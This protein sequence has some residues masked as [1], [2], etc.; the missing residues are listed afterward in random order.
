MQEQ[1][2][3]MRL[4]DAIIAEMD[5]EATTT[6]RLFEVIPEDKLSWQPHPKAMSLGEL[7]MHIAEIP[8]ALAR[9]GQTDVFEFT[10][11]PSPT[12]PE[13]R[14]QILTAFS[15]ALDD[16]KSIV[17]ATSDEQALATWKLTKDSRTLMEM[18]RVAFWRALL[19]NH[20][21]HHRGQL[22]TYLRILD[23]PLPS[24]YGPSA[25]VNPFA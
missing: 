23:V 24:I 1:S 19:L 8:G 4:A 22:S 16:A 5:Q 15:K 3:Q 10:E 13:N 12:R 11:I 18:P 9:L 14:G 20:Y 21:Y 2:K 6:R 7:A 25:D 17:D